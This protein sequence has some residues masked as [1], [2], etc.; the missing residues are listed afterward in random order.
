MYTEWGEILLTLDIHHVASRVQ[1]LCATL[2]E[3]I[4]MKYCLNNAC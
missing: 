1:L 4:N 3:G 2:C